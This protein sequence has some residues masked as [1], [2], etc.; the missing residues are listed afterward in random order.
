MKRP[1]LNALALL[2]ILAVGFTASRSY[3]PSSAGLGVEGVVLPRL[4]SL[5]LVETVFL[6]DEGRIA[7]A[8]ELTERSTPG[9]I[10]ADVLEI[11][12]WSRQHYQPIKCGP[13]APPGMCQIGQTEIYILLRGTVKTVDGDADAYLLGWVMWLD[14]HYIDRLLASNPPETIQE[15]DSFHQRIAQETQ[16]TSGNSLILEQA[17][18]WRG[19][20]VIPLGR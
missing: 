9:G 8:L 20:Q 19:I 7:M 1:I 5:K 4:E 15:L 6:P 13:E 16:E 2:V 14:Q 3:N 10:I 17:V 11:Y 18:T 12:R